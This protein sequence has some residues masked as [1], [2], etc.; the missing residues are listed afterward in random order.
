MQTP[1]RLFVAFT[2]VL[3]D[4]AMSSEA[5]A[6]ALDHFQELAN[7]HGSPTF[8]RHLDDFMARFSEHA[9]LQTELEPLALALKTLQAQEPAH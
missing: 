1:I 8:C 5:K 2:L 6:N 7:S 4:A 3:R 9:D